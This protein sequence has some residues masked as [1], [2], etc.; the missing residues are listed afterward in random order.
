MKAALEALIAKIDSEIDST[1][2]VDRLQQAAT[3]LRQLARNQDDV[4]SLIPQLSAALQEDT[5][6]STAARRHAGAFYTP[7]ALV[8]HCLDQS[9]DPWLD[10]HDPDL[11]PDVLDPCC[12]TGRFLLAAG[13]RLVDRMTADTL[14]SQQEAW[15]KIGPHLHGFDRDPLPIAWL[16]GRLNTLA[17]DDPCASKSIR[18]TDALA[19]GALP[20]ITA[21]VILGNPPFGTPL[22]HTTDAEKIRKRAATVLQQ[23]LGP[24]ADMAAV[25]L[26]LSASALR[27]NGRMSL[28]QPISV[29]AARDTGAIR[30]QVLQITSLQSTW[31]SATSVFD[32]QVHTCVLSLSRTPTKPALVER[33]GGLPPQ[34][35]TP[36]APP[37]I[38][39][40]WSSL[41]TT[42]LGIPDMPPWRTCG[43]LGDFAFAT[44]DFRDQYYGLKGAVAEADK[45]EQTHQGPPLVTTGLIDPAQCAWGHR[46]CR[47]HGQTWKRPIVKLDQ[48]DRNMQNW[49]QARLVPK[50][51]LPTQTRVLEPVLDQTGRWLPSVPIISLTAPD[52]LLGRIGAMLL[53]PLI[54]LLA[55][56]RRLG[57]AR[58]PDAIKLSASDV[59]MLPCPSDECAWDAAAELFVQAHQDGTPHKAL[60]HCANTMMQAYNIP[61]NTATTFLDWWKQRLPKSIQPTDC[62]VISTSF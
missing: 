13:Q 32:A 45:D 34:R 33:F 53:C 14:C 3:L 57:T 9:L 31:A 39:M 2:P 50:V 10:Q 37:T 54:S 7:T 24:Y 11:I 43:T 23:P 36:I 41:A 51:L 27:A 60:S 46:P 8:N 42:A 17:G 49:A 38:D 25:F 59:L 48:L 62:T 30:D 12:G 4:E 15:S 18:Q 55:V 6:S 20:Q 26:L 21:D 19:D 61:E 52:H 28:V 22:R 5:S 35:L 44:A 56:H 29:L 58:T 1:T 47:I 40:T 16:Q